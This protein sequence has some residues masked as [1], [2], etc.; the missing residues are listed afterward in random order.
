MKPLELEAV[1]GVEEL[2]GRA[3][4]AKPIHRRLA[5]IRVVGRP[6]AVGLSPGQLRTRIT[7]AR[8][9]LSCHRIEGTLPGPRA[10]CY[11]VRGAAWRARSPQPVPIT[12]A[13][14]SPEPRR[15]RIP[16]P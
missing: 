5:I 4:P 10:G 13:D 15:P 1:S 3:T 14:D 11:P 12:Y 9:R 16:P 2:V 7:R 8:E 6:L